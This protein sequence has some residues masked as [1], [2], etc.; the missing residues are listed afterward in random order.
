L[1]DRDPGTILRISAKTG[2]GVEEIL[3]HVIRD[4][5]P[6]SNGGD[7]MRALI[8]DSVF[9]QYRGVVCYLRV[10]DGNIRPGQRVAFFSNPGVLYEVLEVGIFRL[11]MLKREELVADGVQRALSR[12]HGA[13]RRAQGG[14]GKALLER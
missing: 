7:K 8:F 14:A 10:T 12:G 11:D 1:L 13:I 2:E 9:D 3:D 5:P 6:P 4:I